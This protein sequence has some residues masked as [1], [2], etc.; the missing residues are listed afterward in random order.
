MLRGV[1]KP[2]VKSLDSRSDLPPPPPPLMGQTIV[3]F[4]FLPRMSFRILLL[5]L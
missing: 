3:D 1:G 5:Q 2:Y 4:V